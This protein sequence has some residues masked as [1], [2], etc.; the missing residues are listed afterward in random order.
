MAQPEMLWNV[1]RG[2]TQIAVKTLKFQ[3][4]LEQVARQDDLQ[5]SL[6]A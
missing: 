3:L 1:C 5:R 2:D 4:C 6:P